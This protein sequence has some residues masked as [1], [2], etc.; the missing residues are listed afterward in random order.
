MKTYH[1]S[2]ET[3]FRGRLS[4]REAELR[5]MLLANED[6][7]NKDDI[8]PRDVQDFKD[9]ASEQSLIT[10]NEAQFEHARHELEQVLTARRR[11]EEGE[12]G[13]CLD[14]GEGIDLRRLTTL[15]ATPYCVACQVIHE[16]SHPPA[17]RS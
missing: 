8:D 3:D 7:P 2:Q 12:Y 1:S 5:E 10:V 9:V 11:L 4:A 6:L 15:P 17:T 16:H 13:Q 14:C